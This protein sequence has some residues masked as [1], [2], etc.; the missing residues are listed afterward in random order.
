M[1]CVIPYVA[2][3]RESIELCISLRHCHGGFAGGGTAFGR[4]LTAGRMAAAKAMLL[5]AEA[6]KRLSLGEVAWRCGYPDQS[7]FARLFRSFF[8][9]TPTQ[10]RNMRKQ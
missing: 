2:P 6:P 7:H 3:A 1:W 10:F 9:C 5:S 4:E 8:G